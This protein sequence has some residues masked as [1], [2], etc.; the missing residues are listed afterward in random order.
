MVKEQ[1][2]ISDSIIKTLKTAPAVMADNS[3]EVKLNGKIQPNENHTAKVFAL[4]SG[5]IQTVNVELGDY[6]KKGQQLAILKSADVAGI[7]NDLSLAEAN[8][9]MAKKSL[10]TAQD[11]Y[12]GKLATEQDYITAKIQYNKALSE[13]NKAKQISSISGGKNAIYTIT[14][15]ISGYIIEKNITNNSEVRQDNNANLFTIAGLE[16]VWITANVYEADM[17]NIQLGDSVIVNTLA[18]PDKNYKGKIDKI[19]N[20][21]DPA[22]RTMQIR[23]SMPNKNGELKPEMFAIVKVN[24]H[25]TGKTLTIPAKAL[26]MDNSKY[27][28][29]QKAGD[30]LAVKEIKL[31]KR[32]EEKAYVKGLTEN[33]QVVT[34]NQVFI[35]QALT[36]N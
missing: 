11:L 12:E 21:L 25:T 9:E 19:Y 36:S 6:V 31:I 13:L 10:Q 34:S 30:S 32:N 17:M 4:V 26:V 3:N 35:Y 24:I 27:Y 29:I 14:A 28:I 5:K 15:P 22:T 16:E 20:I 1:P 18:N 2:A 8:V 33:D 7:T 23:V